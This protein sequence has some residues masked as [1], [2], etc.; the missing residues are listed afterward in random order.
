MLV[1]TLLTSAAQL[2][3]KFGS[4]NFVPG[5]INIITN[6]GIILG[7]ALYGLAAVL[8]IISLKG[9][10][11]SVLY[12]IIATSFIWVNIFSPIFFEDKMNLFKWLGVLII[13]IGVYF[14]GLGG[15]HD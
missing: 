1:T 11:L 13:V 10:E 12:P 9:G 4:N 7:F 14:V 5:I 6:Y 2:S 3:W 8:L 15:K